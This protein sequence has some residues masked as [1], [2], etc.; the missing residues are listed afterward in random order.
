MAR[1]RGGLAA[2]TLSLSLSLSLSLRPAPRRTRLPVDPYVGM[3]WLDPNTNPSSNL[4]PK[5]NPVPKHY[6]QLYAV[7]E[8]LKDE[9]ARETE[10]N[11][12]D[13][14]ACPQ[15]VTN[16]LLLALVV[17]T[18]VKTVFTVDA[19]IWRGW[20]LQEVLLTL[21][22]DNWLG[23]EGA[24]LTDPVGTKT[25]INVVIYLLGDYCAQVIWSKEPR[26]GGALDFD[27]W[28]TARNGLIALIFGP[29]V[30]YYYEF[31]DH[32]LPMTS[33][34]NR[35]AKVHIKNIILCLAEAPSRSVRAGAGAEARA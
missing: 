32:I 9:V 21:P 19:H 22:R 7:D 6:P 16:A 13:T 11:F 17:A 1:M 8:S 23:Y 5:L 34:L 30:H 29:F 33:N 31:S 14:I 3:L 24:L 10:G 15:R 12:W 25:A 4:S 26:E 28:R 35:V 2:L 27:P 18:A 20:T